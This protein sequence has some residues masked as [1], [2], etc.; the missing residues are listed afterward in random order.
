MSW[1][2]RALPVFMSV[3]S[4]NLRKV[5]HPIQIDTKH[6]PFKPR[7]NPG[8]QSQKRS[9]NRTAVT[10]DNTA[11]V[12]QQN[13][14]FKMAKR[15]ELG[16]LTPQEAEAARLRATG[17]SQA[18][19]WRQAFNKRRVKPQTAW[20]EASKVFAKPK[21]S[22][23]VAELLRGLQALDCTLARTPLRWMG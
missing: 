22:Q 21:V 2:N 16:G 14:G 15:V 12:Q 6:F 3:S 17:L 4:E 10:C 18:E 8:S 7:R 5:L 1:A 9:V 13:I 11:V 23:R 19:A 20:T